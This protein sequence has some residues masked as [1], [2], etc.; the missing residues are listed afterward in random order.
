MAHTVGF[1]THSYLSKVERGQKMP[2][3]QLILDISRFFHV[4]SDLLLKDELELEQE[5]PSN[6]KESAS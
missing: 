2:T 5:L 1:A 6:Q 3:S 4:S